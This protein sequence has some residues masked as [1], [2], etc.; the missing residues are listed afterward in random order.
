M[1]NRES[2]FTLIEL[3]VVITIIGI[4]ASAAIPKLMTAIDKA[5]E[6]KART[7][8]TSLHSALEMYQM[9]YNQYIN[10]TGTDLSLLV[11]T[12]YMGGIPATPYPNGLVYKGSKTAYSIGCYYNGKATVGGNN[13]P[14]WIVYGSA[15]DTLAICTG[16][17][18][19]W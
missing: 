15:N 9:D 4:L 6:T 11:S 8:I 1:K 2:G 5:K 14:Y 18:T 13:P 10:Q 17:G 16:S 7:I 3:L 19:A 12:K